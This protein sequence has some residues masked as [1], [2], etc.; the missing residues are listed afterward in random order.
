MRPC[1]QEVRGALV[2]PRSAKAAARTLALFPRNPRAA[3]VTVVPQA[4]GL[5]LRALL[6]GR[7]AF[8]VP[9]ALLLL[10]FGL[11]FNAKL[12]SLNRN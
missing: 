10:W 2:R 12:Q 7:Y 4:A 1:D 5:L 11:R 9:L 8:C 3:D 6:S